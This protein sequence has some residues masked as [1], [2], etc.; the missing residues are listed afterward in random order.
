MEQVAVAVR[1]IPIVL[2]F[3]GDDTATELH[4]G[5]LALAG[6]GPRKVIKNPTTA[7]E[8]MLCL[9]KPDPLDARITQVF[10]AN[11]SS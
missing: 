2:A 8:I 10:A 11:L 7:A 3:V 5:T 4:T 9:S 1:T 6:R